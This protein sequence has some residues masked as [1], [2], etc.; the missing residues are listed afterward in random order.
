MRS[1]GM[2]WMDSL[3]SRWR[4]RGRRRLEYRDAPGSNLIDN[5]RR[6]VTY[7]LRGMARAPGFALAAITAIA[8][9]IGANTAFFS[10]VY[11]VL[12]RPLPVSNPETIRNVHIATFG[13]G[14][15]AHY[16]TRYFVAWSEFQQM[17]ASSR[18]A[19]LAGIAEV[20]MGRKG[21]PRP[22]RAQLVSDNL[23][24][25]MGGRP[26]LGRFFLPEETS[27]PGGAAS[28]VLSYRAWRDWFASSAS[29]IGSLVIL[30]RT[31]FTVVGVADERTT[32]P[33]MMLPDVWIPLTMQPVTRS[34]EPLIY[35]SVNAWVQVFARRRPGYDDAALKAEM[36][37]LARAAIQQTLPKRTVQVTVAPG[38]FLNFPFAQRQF[39]PILGIVFLAITLVLIVACANVANMLLARGLSR[40]REIAIRLSI[41]AGRKRLMQQL[42][43]ESV[44]LSAFGAVAGLFLAQVAISGIM[45][46]IPLTDLGANQISPSPD[47]TIVLYTAAVA[48]LTGVVFGLLPAINTLRFDL[49]PALK[50]EGLQ[51]STGK[52]GSGRLQNG[53]IAVQIAVSLVLLFNAGLLIRGFRQAMVFDTGQ[54][55]RNL[56]IADLNLRQQRYTAEEAT[57]FV[58]SLRNT[59]SLLPGIAAVSNT[60]VEPLREQCGRTAS[61]GGPEI[62]VSCDE[63][64]PDYLRAA[65]IPLLHGR[66]FSPAEM[67]NQLPVA[68][69]D[70]R[71]A[72]EHLGSENAVGRSFR[73]HNVDYQVVGVAGVTRPLDL[74]SRT[75]PKIYW[76]MRGLRH[77]EAKMLVRY[78][79]SAVEAAEAIRKAAAALDGNV[80]AAVRRVEDSMDSVLSPVRIAAAAA[81]TLGALALVLAATGIYGVVA[82]AIGRRRR[83]VGIRM[84]LG[85]DRRSVCRL[86][87]WQGGKPVLIGAAIGLLAAGGASQLIR[88]M[89]YGVSPLDPMSFAVTCVLLGLV[90]LAAMVVPVRQALRVD[91]AVTL[92][93]D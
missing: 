77:N 8:L 89:L 64:G 46:M 75:A 76:P 50:S 68:I 53:L 48:L 80:N 13:E 16:G 4:S 65:G 79:G 84:A 67:L 33:L 82:F 24:P 2:R 31:P 71:F 35:D 39:G 56:L 73:S 44:L 40:R 86:V 91:P 93:Y 78:Q 14:R 21:D 55:T 22:V 36:E 1:T 29:V 47:L 7:T 26:L 38:A 81:S 15:R 87:L 19:E 11:S 54:D 3:R 59:A 27:R 12:L 52:R 58:T 63:V 9:G 69:V 62:V 6:D 92:R 66:E 37:V 34:G 17:R 5:M 41:G 85:A 72:R 70:Q 30:N 61:A 43:T 90:A 23:L 32:G 45:A 88:A 20:T 49:T 74:T 18:T 10:L 51:A 28:V 60:F 42:M 83:E 57:R 25:L